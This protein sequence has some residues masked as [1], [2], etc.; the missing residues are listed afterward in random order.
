MIQVFALFPSNSGTVTE[1]FG[2]I[3]FVEYS[4]FIPST[5]MDKEKRIGGKE[6][7][8]QEEQRLTCRLDLAAIFF[9]C[10]QIDYFHEFLFELKS[11]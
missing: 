9:F 1:L 5:C 4:D 11:T 8:E 7:R 10:E 6:D 3:F 2:V